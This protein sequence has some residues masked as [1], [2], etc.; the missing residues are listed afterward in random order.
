MRFTKLIIVLLIVAAAALF[1]YWKKTHPEA[2]AVSVTMV[3]KGDVESTVANTRAG[4]VMACRRAKMSPSLGGQISALPY[5]EGAA[6]KQNDILLE[7]WNED[8]RAEVSHAESALNSARDTSQASCLQAGNARRTADRSYKLSKSGHVSQQEY[9]RVRSEAEAREAE[10]HAAKANVSVAK[11][12]LEIAKTRLERTILY[13]P[14]DGVIANING[15]L[16]EYVTPSPPGILT[17]PVIDLI[18]PNCF[19]LSA[20]IDEV[21]APKVQLGMAARIT[22][23]S[24]R[25]RV[26]PATVKRIGS[27]IVD[28]EKQARTVD[29]EFDF[30]NTEDLSALLVGYSA[31][32]DIILDT[33]KDVLRIPTEAL[34][35]ENHVFVYLPASQTLEKRV[36]TKGISNWTFTEVTGGLFAGDQ[37]IISPGEPGVDDGAVA[38]LSDN[39]A[40][41]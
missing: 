8:L 5:K 14:F 13:A 26:F 10:C 1:W 41:D 32:V 23:D 16:N 18:E 33:R 40:D 4:T 7:L 37:I 22:L 39:P 19:Y 25:G 30:N 35:D 36:V 3:E 9:D 34:L 11:A 20:P 17:P 6:V 12:S 31:D 38:R 24:W 29:V 2:V 15:E 27:Y 21:D 28:N